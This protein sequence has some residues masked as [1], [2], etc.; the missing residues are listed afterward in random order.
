MVRQKIAETMWS[1]VDNEGRSYSVLKEIVDH[2]TNG[3]ALLKDDGYAV[4]RSGRRNPK[5][6]TQGYELEVE[7][8]DCT[9][10]WVPLKDLKDSNPVPL[11]EY[12]VANKNFRGTCVRLV[13]EADVKA[14]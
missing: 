4:D 2:R 6:T 8:R 7:W 11:A 13:G 12:A 1:Q 10:S 5:V 9:T 14:A 3:H